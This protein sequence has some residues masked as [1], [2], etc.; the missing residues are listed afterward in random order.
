V[1]A[2]PALPQEEQPGIPKEV[3]GMWVVRTDVTSPASVS[4]VVTA[5]RK[6]GLNTLFVQCRGR[7]DAYYRSDL[8]PRAQALVKSGD[9][10]DPLAKMVADGHAAGLKVHAW[11]NACY[12]WSEKHAPTA[13]G[14]IVRARKDWL[15]VRCTGDR[16]MVGNAEVFICPGNPEA[17]AHLVAVCRDIAKRYEVDGI[18]LDY[19]RYANKDL[20]YCNG[21]LDR[22]AATL[23]GAAPAELLVALRKK[24]RTALPNAFKSSWLQFRRDQIT[25]L[26]REIRTAVK[27][28]RSK[29]LLSAAVIAWGGYPGSFERTEAY[30]QVGQDWYGWIRSGLVDAVCPMT[31]QTQTAG[32][33]AWVRAIGRSHPDFPVWYGIGAYLFSSDSAAAKVETVRKGRGKGWVLFSYTSVTRSGTD[34]S[35]LRNLKARVLGPA[36]AGAPARSTVN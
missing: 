25:S 8:E 13:P 32:F 20:C 34:D 36:S 23:D 33:G 24:G 16:C 35:Y 18:Q 31:Y 10:F 26:V 2:A 22:F 7:G 11:V 17:R 3:R 19:I 14:H 4:R 21:C 6:N 9:A 15:A 28:E 30:N 27:A 29:A 12:V 5:A 1:V